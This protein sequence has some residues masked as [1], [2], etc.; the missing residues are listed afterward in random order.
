MPFHLCQ[1]YLSMPLLL[2]RGFLELPLLFN[3]KGS[4]HLALQTLQW[5]KR[6]EIRVNEDGVF[7]YLSMQNFLVYFFTIIFYKLVTCCF[8][9]TLLWYYR[10]IYTS[11]PTKDGRPFHNTRLGFTCSWSYYK[12]RYVNIESRQSS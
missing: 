12:K 8:I 9:Y 11:S 6:K 7:V 4:T 3:R 10:W 5:T 1:V 2:C